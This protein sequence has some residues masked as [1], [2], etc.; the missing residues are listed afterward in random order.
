MNMSAQAYE[1]YK[2]T[3]VETISPGKLLLMLYDGAIRNIKSARSAIRE[4]DYNQAHTQIIKAQDIL[5]E[6]MATL[7]MDYDIA[8]H[9]FSLYDFLYNQLVEANISKNDALLEE[10]QEF[11]S[12]LRDTWEEAV[13]IQGRSRPLKL[14]NQQLSVKG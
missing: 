14:E 12:E 3:S 7:N 10:V 6:L 8:G 5:A 9:L 4:K 1:Q 13:K 2:K 11:L